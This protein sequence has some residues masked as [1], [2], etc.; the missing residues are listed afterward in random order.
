MESLNLKDLDSFF[1]YF[2]PSQVG[3]RP[4]FVGIDGGTSIIPPPR[5]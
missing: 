1:S 4:K 3:Q 5:L 2:S